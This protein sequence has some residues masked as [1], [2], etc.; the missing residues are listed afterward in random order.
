MDVRRAIARRLEIGAPVGGVSDAASRA[1][2]AWAKVERP[3]VWRDSARVVVIGGPTLGGSGK[4]PLAIAVAQELQKRGHRVALVGHAY[5]ASPQRA[6]VVLLEDDVRVVG[7]EALVCAG[8]L[9]ELGI[10]VVVGPSRQDALNLALALADVA[11][12]DGP[13]QTAP[14]RASLALLAVDAS[15]PWGSG[16]CPPRGDLKASVEATLAATDRVVVV[17]EGSDSVEVVSEGAW[18]QDASPRNLLL[19]WDSLRT[20]RVGLWT[21]LARPERLLQWLEKRGVRPVELHLGT[22]HAKGSP[23]RSLPDAAVPVDLWLT[24]A[25]C[26]T[27]LPPATPGGVPVATLDHALRLKSSLRE[28]LS[29]LDPRDT[30]P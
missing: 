17:G 30:R 1:W 20:L 6:R 25:K 15:A 24:T 19:G 5:G 4:T 18:L 12:V 16:H 28:V 29:R 23:K 27:H 2:A 7:D 10:P 26:R 13:C 14:R 3:L 22:D 8:R 9:A 21:A 11:V